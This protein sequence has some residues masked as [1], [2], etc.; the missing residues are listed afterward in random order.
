MCRARTI[1]AP[2]ATADDAIGSARALRWKWVH[3]RGWDLLGSSGV[4]TNDLKL[5][6]N[7]PRALRPGGLRQAKQESML[8]GKNKFA[9]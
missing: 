8:N 9:N 7:S 3:S 1:P 6:T 2:M 4:K 5:V